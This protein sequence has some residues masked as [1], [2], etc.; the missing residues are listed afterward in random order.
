MPPLQNLLRYTTPR[1]SFVGV[2]LRGHPFSTFCR[3]YSA[4]QPQQLNCDKRCFRRVV[5]VS[6]L[7]QQAEELVAVI[8]AQH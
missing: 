1:R 7:A 6:Q 5:T 8:A 4:W 3:V 2:A